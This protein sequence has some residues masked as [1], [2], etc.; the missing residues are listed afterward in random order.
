M[1][2][3][4]A[5]PPGTTADV[6]F[7]G[8]DLD[9]GSGLVLMIREHMLLVPVGGVLE[10]KS[11]EP[12]VGDDLPPWC[13]MAGHEYLGRIDGASPGQAPGVVRY[14]VRRG[15]QEQAASEAKALADDKAKAKDYV[16]RLRTRATG[17]QKATVYCR[18][19]SWVL[20][21]SASFEEKDAH[22]SA[23]EALLGALGGSLVTA[24]ATQCARRGIE[25]DDIELT[26]SGKL[27]NILA[28]LGLEEG[29][30]SFAGIEV[31]CYASTLDDEA[32]AR[33]V[34]EDVVARSP[35]AATLAKATTLTIK[36]AVV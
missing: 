34:F 23:V 18:N 12:T 20:G 15:A 11:S 27:H 10:M 4:L 22:P 24:F 8:G 2:G 17:H 14:F 25:V 28:H 33:A 30:P 32:A 36:F 3:K 9:C 21:Q 29:D 16:W 6:V 7:D 19:F 13:R 35:I 5:P 1:S 26:V 31:K